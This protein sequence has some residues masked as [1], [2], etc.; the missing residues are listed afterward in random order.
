LS[1]SNG[2]KLVPTF[3]EERVDGGGCK[4]AI[5]GGILGI[6]KWLA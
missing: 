5:K 2:F 6:K 1:N 4:V 3:G